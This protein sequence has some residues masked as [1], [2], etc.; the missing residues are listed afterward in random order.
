MF[1]GLIEEIGVVRG[2]SRSY[3]SLKLSINKPFSFND[4]SIGESVSLNGACL[5]I[6]KLD[7]E[8]ITFDVIEESLGRT[9]LGDLKKGDKVN[10]E[11]AIK[12]GQ[13]MGGHFVTGHIDY[14]AQIKRV[15]INK[16]NAKLEITLPQEYKRYVV[17][18]GSISVDG[19]SLTVGE[20]FSDRFLVYL[21]PHTLEGTTLGLRR[22]GDIVNIEVDMLPKYALKFEG[23]EEASKIDMS[24]LKEHG[25]V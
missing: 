18:K 13:R 25:F 19:V 6:A 12:I 22:K 8:L 16:D 21:I 5:T 17:P 1:T 2:L 11:R 10:L 24:F 3:K 14:K 23:R 20:A 7:K 4:V 9:N 15:D